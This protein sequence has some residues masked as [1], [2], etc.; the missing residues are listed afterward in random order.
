MGP[1]RT[2]RTSIDESEAHAGMEEEMRQMSMGH[3][4]EECSHDPLSTFGY[5]YSSPEEREQIKFQRK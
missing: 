2:S 4:G 1:Q 3:E 5:R